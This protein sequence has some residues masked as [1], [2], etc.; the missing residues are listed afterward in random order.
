LNVEVVEAHSGPIG[1]DVSHEFMLITTAGEDKFAK[2]LN[3]NY[4]A[5]TEIAKIKPPSINYS[6]KNLEKIEKVFTPNVSTVD[7]LVKFLNKN[8]KDFVKS[9]LYKVNSE[10]VLVLV[11]G[12]K[13]VNI[14]KLSEYLKADVVLASEED[15]K[16]VGSVLGFIGPIN[17]PKKIRIIADYSVVNLKDVIV[18][19]NEKDYHY[20]GIDFENIPIDEFADVSEVVDG[21]VCSKCGGE[22]RIFP[23]LE[24]G[25]IFKLGTK[26]SEPLGAYF[27][28]KDGKLKPMIMGCYGIGVSRIIS[29]ILEAYSTEDCSC[30]TFTST[31]FHVYLLTINVDDEDQFKYSLSIYNQLLS[32]GIEVLWDDRKESPG[33]KFKD[34]ELLGIPFCIVVGSK[35]KDN[36]VE[37]KVNKNFYKL[38]KVSIKEICD[39]EEVSDYVENVIRSISKDF[40]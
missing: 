26:Y 7:H 16:E 40:N 12:D 9:I 19:A 32:K 34:W 2:C 11:R 4:S 33:T 14:L 18:G 39:Y 10:Y 35:L 28:D 37:L 1:G 29:A 25:H 38:L 20:T 30:W 17:L 13:E 24:L 27:N 3:C 21:D 8:V 23:A 5:S 15:F 6:Y 22:Y 36:K 31:P